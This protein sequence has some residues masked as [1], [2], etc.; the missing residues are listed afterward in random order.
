MSFI[1]WEYK[2]LFKNREEAG[3]RLAEFLRERGVKAEAVVSLLRGGALLGK[4]IAKEFAL[5]HYPLL[6]VKIGAPFNEELAIGAMIEEKIF[7]NTELLGK[8]YLSEKEKKEAVEKARKKQEEY[9]E[10]LGKIF[11]E[12]EKVVKD[13][14]VLVVDDGLATGTSAL[15]A[16]EYLKEK[17]AKKV[18]TAVP[19]APLEIDRSPFD[20]LLVYFEDPFFVAVGEFYEDFSSLPLFKVKEIFQNGSQG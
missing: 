18:I 9:Q 13:K 15:V 17:G 4:E 10:A 20:E 11:P 6:V 12:W 5:P 16:Q 3:K 19:A 8:L 1:V 14:T 2:P 7:W